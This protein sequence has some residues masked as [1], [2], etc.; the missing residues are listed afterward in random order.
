MD[1]TGKTELYASW[2]Q[3]NL[4]VADQSRSTGSRLWVHSGTGTDSTGYGKSDRKSVV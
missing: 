3:G 2:L 4:V 1:K